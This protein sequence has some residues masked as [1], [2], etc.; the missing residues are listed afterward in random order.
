MT[1]SSKLSAI[2]NDHA[3]REIAVMVALAGFLIVTFHVLI[4]PMHHAPPV[5]AALEG[6]AGVI[7]IAGA[8][9]AADRYSARLTRRMRAVVAAEDAADVAHA[10]QVRAVIAAARDVVGALDVEGR[11]VEY[12]VR[13]TLAPAVAALEPKEGA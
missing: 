8:M 13:R 12:H 2:W 7:A 1:A 9:M 5:E 4:G 10:L 11:D 6:L 3:N